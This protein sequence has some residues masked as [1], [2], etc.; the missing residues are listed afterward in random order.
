MIR[1]LTDEE[2]R[3][4]LSKVLKQFRDIEAITDANSVKCDGQ[5]VSELTKIARQHPDYDHIRT[6]DYSWL[7]VYLVK[8]VIREKFVVDFRKLRAD[9]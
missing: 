8:E 6:G 3:A 2:T 9:G 4:E 7:R 1:E 5:D